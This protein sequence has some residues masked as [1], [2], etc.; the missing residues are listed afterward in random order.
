MSEYYTHLTAEKLKTGTSQ[1]EL[2][3]WI[4][5]D[6]VPTINKMGERMEVSRAKSLHLPTSL[7]KPSENAVLKVVN[8]VTRPDQKWM[9][10]HYKEIENIVLQ[11]IHQYVTSEHN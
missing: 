10:K 9:D 6:L 8:T 4:K 2:V 11:D 3:Q 1:G 5:N 7:S